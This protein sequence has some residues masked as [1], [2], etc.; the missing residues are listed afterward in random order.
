MAGKHRESP[1]R[2]CW[3]IVRLQRELEQAR[4]ELVK[5][6]SRADYVLVQK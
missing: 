5:Q 6:G 3:S 2:P 1:T 4:K